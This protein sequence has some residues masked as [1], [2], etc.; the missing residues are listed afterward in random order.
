MSHLVGKCSIRT[1]WKLLVL[2]YLTIIRSSSTTLHNWQLQ[3]WMCDLQY[4]WLSSLLGYNAL[5]ILNLL[6]TWG[7]A[8]CFQLLGSQRRIFLPATYYPSTTLKMNRG[9]FRNVSNKLALNMASHSRRV[10]FLT[11]KCVSWQRKH[12]KLFLQRILVCY[13]MFFKIVK[14]QIIFFKYSYMYIHFWTIF[15][16]SVLIVDHSI[17]LNFTLLVNTCNYCCENKIMGLNMAMLFLLF[18]V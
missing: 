15:I 17:V 16:L 9:G 11:S 5:L 14:V 2:L 18:L 7:S 12:R 1:L 10:I 3:E 8:S 4:C 6:L 13:M